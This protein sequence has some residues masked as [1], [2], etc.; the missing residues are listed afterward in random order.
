MRTRAQHSGAEFAQAQTCVAV[1]ADEHTACRNR[2]LPWR[3]AE[4]RQAARDGD[5]NLPQEGHQPGA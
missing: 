4:L 3:E 5:E 1:L 2:R